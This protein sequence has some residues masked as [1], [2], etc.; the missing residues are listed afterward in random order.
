MRLSKVKLAGFKSFVDPTTL[1]LPSNLVAVVGPNGCGKSNVID[2]VRWVMGES[3]AKHL[4]GDSMADVIFNGSTSRKPVGHASIELIFDNTEG[5]VGGQYATYNEIAVKRQV[6]RDG[7]STYFLNGSRCRRRDITDLFLGTGLGPRSYAIIE[8]GTISR[9]IEAKPEELRGFIEEAAG[10]SKFKERRRE[11]ENR[12]RHTQ[13]NL[14]RLNDLRDELGKQLERLQ[15]QA[16]TAERYKLL[17]EEERLLKAQ[18]QALRWKGLKESAE[19]EERRMGELENAYQAG[20]ATQRQLEASIEKERDAQVEATDV[21]NEVQGRFYAVGAD[22]GRIEQAIQHGRERQ[23]QL[24]Q[25]LARAERNW[26]EASRNLTTDQ[27]ELRGLRDAL[28]Q[29]EPALEQER[30]LEEQSSLIFAE[31]EEAMHAWQASWETLSQQAAEPA[32]GADVERTRIQHLDQDV[33]QIEQRMGRLREE[34]RALDTDALE[35]EVQ[36]LGVQLAEADAVRGELEATLAETKDRIGAARAAGSRLSEQLHGKRQT[37]QSQRGRLSSLEALQQE[38][39]GKGQGAVMDWLTSNGLNDQSRLAERIEVQSGWE[40]AVETV[41]GHHLEAVC[42]EEISGVAEQATELQ[43]GVLGLFD[44]STRAAEDSAPDARASLAAKVQAPWPVETL[45]GGVYATDS[46]AE[47][48]SRRGRLAAHESC[49]T[50]DGVWLG[51][52]WLRIN[53]KADEGAGVLGREQEIRDIGAQLSALTD[54]I[55]ELEAHFGTRQE[56][57]RMLEDEQAQLQTRLGEAHRRHGTL[58][59]QVS[60]KQ[61]RLE[62]LRSRAERLAEEL[63]ELQAQKAANEQRIVQ[64]RG[65]LE[66]NL[67][68]MQELSQRREDLVLERD[69]R[70]RALDEA[71]QRRREVRERMHQT[72]LRVESMRTRR[73]SLAKGLDRTQEQVAQFASRR[74]EM[75]LALSDSE[76]PLVEGRADLERKLA[77][78]MTVEA[79]LKEARTRVE[80]IDARLRELDQGRHRADEVVESRRGQLEQCRVNHQATEVRL[81]TVLE[82]LTELGHELTALID[83]L[84]EDASGEQWQTRVEDMERRIGRLGPINLAAIDE[85]AQQSERKEYLDAQFQDLVEALTTLES[86][87]RKID[88]ETRTRFKET[89]DRI[90]SGLQDAF[91]RLFG[92]GHSYLELTSEDLLESGVTVMARPPGKRNSTIHLLSGGEKALTAVALVFSI[93]ELNPAPFCLLDEVDAPLDDANVGRFCSMVRSMSDRVQFMFITHNK[94]TMEL[95]NHLIGVTMHEPGVSRLVAV[96]VD[97]AVQMAAV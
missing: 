75:R 32:R 8:Q 40:M 4:R 48:I 18:L 17:K 64:A 34:S 89:F 30:A 37:L 23:E 33:L 15:R 19:A 63:D 77:K 44:T 24:R 87:I 66:E 58:H 31:A 85:Y 93:F 84:P 42:V 35:R 43:E 78:R 9:I 53:R 61:A 95:S 96:D 52:N 59:S 67:Q 28:A 71:R 74:E 86:A 21:F 6:S 91:P 26:E 2:A 1:M 25:E 81:Q 39:L 94:I 57:L 90:N 56:E 83:E 45:L 88:R 16:R 62:Q 22:I 72:A 47:A 65:R 92:G 27:E 82:Q 69:E 49:I 11:T 41:L 12:I 38:A 50:P 14:D 10:I 80:H 36:A 97:E 60:A 54:E 29:R 70:R 7:Q 20:V 68:L 76:S 3:S 46:L 73:D 51:G 5:I 79:E 13:E 55:A